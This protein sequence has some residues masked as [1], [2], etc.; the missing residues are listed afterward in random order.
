MAMR[1]TD[2]FGRRRA[3]LAM[4]FAAAFVVWTSAPDLFSFGRAGV[5]P[6]HPDELFWTEADSTL[7]PE[8]LSN[9]A[10]YDKSYPATVHITSTVL[11]RDWFLEIYPQESTDR[12]F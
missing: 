4:L 10:I 1:E 9:I 6:L 8:E 7:T 2:S 3:I 5:S 11:H 12:G